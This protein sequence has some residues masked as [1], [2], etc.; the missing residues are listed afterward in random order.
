MP[1]PFEGLLPYA[2]MTAFLDWQA[3]AS[4]SLDTGIMVGR[5]TDTI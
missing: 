4:N 5:M 1:V 3:M 2:I